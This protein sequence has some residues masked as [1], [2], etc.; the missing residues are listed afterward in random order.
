[1]SV[2]TQTTSLDALRTSV[3]RLRSIVEPLD[4][5]L[6]GTATAEDFAPQTWDEWNAET[7]RAQVVDGLAADAALL[8]ALEALGADQRDGFTFAM[9]R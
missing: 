9:G 2:P 3:R 8:A 4:D 7:P 6:A 5:E 1:M